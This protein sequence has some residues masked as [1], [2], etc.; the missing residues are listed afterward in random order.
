MY[1]KLG[2]LDH[3]SEVI[4]EA[5]ELRK[6]HLPEGHPDI[7]DSESELGVI[8]RRSGRLEEAETRLQAVLAAR[9]S[10][11]G[12]DPE[13]LAR[14]LSNLGNLYWSELRYAGAEKPHRRALDPRSVNAHRLGTEQALADEA[15]SANNLGAILLSQRRYAEARLVLER[16]V[17]IFRE[18]DRALLGSALTN[19]G[20][21]ERSLESWTRSERLFR[22][23]IEVH[24]ATV[25]PCT[26][27]LCGLI[28]A[29]CS[30]S[31][32]G[33]GSTRPSE[34]GAR[35]R[36]RRDS[37]RSRDA[38]PRPEQ[39]GKCAPPGR[40]WRRGAR[41][42]CPQHGPRDLGARRRHPTTLQSRSYLTRALSRTGHVETA[43]SELADI[44]RLQNTVLA[45]AHSARLR[46][47]RFLAE[48]LLLAGRPDEAEAPALA[49]VDRKRK[50][51]ES[52]HPALAGSLHSLARVRVAQGQ[53]GEAAS[54]FEAAL[55]ILRQVYAE[56]HPKIA[57]TAHELGVLKPLA[58]TSKGLGKRL[59]G[60]SGSGGPSIPPAIRICGSRRRSWLGWERPPH[61]AEAS[62]DRRHSYLGHRGL[63][64]LPQHLTVDVVEPLHV[65]ARSPI[66]DSARARPYL[67]ECWC[68]SA[69]VRSLFVA[70]TLLAACGPDLS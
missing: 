20:I 52:P 63:H 26:S 34:S 35:P 11:P 21:V 50:R 37:R 57:E 53:L 19:L 42:L 45:P 69:P 27:V 3:A 41:G 59:G 44:D 51:F 12:V 32:S 18:G 43:V 46:T 55:G 8:A 64:Q 7:V 22:E 9:E 5:L 40:S 68:G 1:T 67:F 66:A 33:I 15:I 28:A 61:E 31:C 39:L 60:Q 2:E 23:A 10:D 56:T 70:T 24:E 4:G 17:S 13:L 6:Q 58:R 48:A 14:A 29:S 54:L 30:S 65:Q 49:V 38:R 47:A 36:K 62:A 25:G 16:A